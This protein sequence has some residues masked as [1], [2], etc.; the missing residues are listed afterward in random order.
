MSAEVQFCD[1]CGGIYLGPPYYSIEPDDC[2]N[3]IKALT[4]E[5]DSEHVCTTS[6]C[7]D[8]AG[9]WLEP[10]DPDDKRRPGV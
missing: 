6:L 8:C 4:L 7:P 9:P 1:D 10:D 5:D 3:E 2:S